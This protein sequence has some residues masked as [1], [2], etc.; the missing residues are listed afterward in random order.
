MADPG[1]AP[2]DPVPDYLV[3]EHVEM[4][5]V[6]DGEEETVTGILQR[7]DGGYVVLDGHR[8]VPIVGATVI[9]V[10]PA[11]QDHRDG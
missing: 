9:G 3:G 7:A 6:H 5:Y 8:V 10:G 2:T 4:R 11:G 1:T